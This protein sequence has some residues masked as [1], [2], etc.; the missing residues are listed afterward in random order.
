MHTDVS[1]QPGSPA[2]STLPGA[3]GAGRDGGRDCG[4]APRWGRWPCQGAPRALSLAAARGFGLRS[5]RLDGFNR[6][7]VCSWRSESFGVLLGVVSWVRK[8][9]S[10]NLRSEQTFVKF[11]PF[12][13]YMAVQKSGANA[14]HSDKSR[15]EQIFKK[16]QILQTFRRSQI[17]E[18]T[19]ATCGTLGPGVLDPAGTRLRPSRKG[20]GP[21]A[22]FYQDRL[23][24][25]RPS[26][27]R[28]LAR[29][30]LQC[31]AVRS[32]ARYAC[33]AVPSSGTRH[34]PRVEG[35]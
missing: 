18:Q 26:E 27:S 1:T 17:L 25:L 3:S 21:S 5:G 15:P 35:S 12:R 11:A 20:A 14:T 10:Q 8:F 6:S 24:S 30:V 28:A 22:W 31:S 29:G 32:G 2:S 9:A 4:A 33:R 19:L 7:R 16:G 13:T 23:A 34:G